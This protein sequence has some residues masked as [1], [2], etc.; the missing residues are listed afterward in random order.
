MERR[1]R[2]RL[3]TTGLL[4]TGA[5]LVSCAPAVDSGECS[6]GSGCPRGEMCNLAEAV[7]ELIDLPTDATE[8]PAPATFTNKNIPF[9]RG[10]VCT[11]TETAPGEAFPVF[12][13]PC[14]H[15]CL[16][17]SKFEFKHSWTCQGSSCD[18]YAV[19]WMNVDAASA[20]PEDAFGQFPAGQCQYTTPVTLSIDP[21]YGD[22][23]PVKGSMALEI[24]FLSNEDAEA[25]A[26]ADGGPGVTESRMAQYAPDPA[27]IV[28]GAPIS[29][30]DSHPAPPADC[31][32]DGSGCDCF[33]IGF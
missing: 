6:E 17:V 11:V 21:V 29:I 19:L 16:D 24:P 25:I 1:N 5:L 26:A 7:C 14:L 30:L 32:P 10:R 8:S 27:R 31:G 28:G 9:F 4:S 20:C 13:N 3:L 23:A 2:L 22:G 15:P 18:A 33:E 12:I